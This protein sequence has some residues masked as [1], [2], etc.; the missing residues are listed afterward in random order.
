MRIDG[1]KMTLGSADQSGSWGNNLG[2]EQSQ[3]KVAAVGFQKKLVV[4]R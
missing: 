2:V 1:K 4:D 3:T